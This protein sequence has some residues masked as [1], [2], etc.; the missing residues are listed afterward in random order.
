MTKLEKAMWLSALRDGK[1][2]QGTEYLYRD[3]KFCCLGVLEEIIGTPK[4]LACDMGNA[5]LWSYG[6][7]MD[8]VSSTDW[9][10][11]SD[12]VLT[13]ATQKRFESDEAGLVIPLSALS[14]EQQ[15]RLEAAGEVGFIKDE[16]RVVNLIGLNDAGLTFLEIADIIDVHLPTTD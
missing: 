13:T 11:R 7:D 15:I 16:I 1:Y 9:N 10:C 8:P 14:V 5:E 4:A 12:C 3:N 2:E 6:V